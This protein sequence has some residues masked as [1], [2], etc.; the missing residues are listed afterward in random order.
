MCNI[1]KSLS[2]IITSIGLSIK[3]VCMELHFGKHNILFIFFLSI[4]PFKRL[5]NVSQY[6]KLYAFLSIV[7][8]ILSPFVIIA[9]IDK[10][11][12]KI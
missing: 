12:K 4:S 1:F 8:N 2:V 10:N 9:C 5:K 6:S 11:V 3:Q 7:I